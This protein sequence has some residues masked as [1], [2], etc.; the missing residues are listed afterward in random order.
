MQRSPNFAITCLLTLQ[1]IV[2]LAPSSLGGQQSSSQTGPCTGK[3]SQETKTLFDY[4]SRIDL[5][6]YNL[7]PGKYSVPR[8]GGAKSVELQQEAREKAYETAFS[9]ISRLGLSYDRAREAYYKG[10]RELRS[11]NDQ[12]IL[13]QDIKIYRERETYDWDDCKYTYEVELAVPKFPGLGADL[14]AAL[15]RALQ[16]KIKLSRERP[17]DSSEISLVDLVE[18]LLNDPV[19]KKKLAEKLADER[20]RDNLR[21]K[22]DDTQIFMDEASRKVAEI[23]GYPKG[24]YRI[25]ALAGSIIKQVVLPAVKFYLQNYGEVKVDCEGYTDQLRIVSGIPYTGSANLS[26]S[27]SPS[28]FKP[29][30]PIAQSLI[31]NND[32]LSA[33]RAYEGIAA[34]ESA[35]GRMSQRS[36][37][38]L[39]YFG[40]GA[41]AS[42]QR[43]HPASRKIIFRIHFSKLRG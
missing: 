31:R 35:L 25:N 36:G 37:L 30:S 42:P 34:L 41:A 39:R 4:R 38:S 32:Q 20:F 17:R 29:A 11:H 5:S 19:F 9:L 13:R 26:A 2:L 15:S 7:V 33:A 43:D 12:T 16:G 23:T 10:Y 1:V 22:D 8:I 27:G 6:L 18:A 14:D 3:H 24:Q 40:Q 28:D 21:F